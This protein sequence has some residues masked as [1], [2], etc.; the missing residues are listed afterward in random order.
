VP[1]G[2][3]LFSYAWDDNAGNYVT[4]FHEAFVL[5]LKT[6]LRGHPS[7]L[8]RLGIG[9]YADLVF[10]D[11]ETKP[12]MGVLESWLAARAAQAEF[13]VLFIDTNYLASD[14]CLFEWLA[15]KE[16]LGDAALE[17][18]LVIEL[19]KGLV[20][21]HLD[22]LKRDMTAASAERA[23]RLEAVM[24]CVRNEFFYS[25]GARIPHYMHRNGKWSLTQE[26]I[27][28]I[29]PLAKKSQPS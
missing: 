17:R 20:R 16:R 9:D 29:E 3:V 4:A 10:F 6:A 7:A 22:A 13:L 27:D 25:D 14:W 5:G 21:R 1:T 12:S 8:Q 23:A 11:Q 2:T 15:F 19:E 26:F 28:K 18:L 24:A